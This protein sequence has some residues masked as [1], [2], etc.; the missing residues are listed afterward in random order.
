VKFAKWLVRAA[1]PVLFAVSVAGCASSSTSTLE[2]ALGNSEAS[3]AAPLAGAPGVGADPRLMQAS[4]AG[5]P[6]V[7]S[8]AAALVASATPG[9]EGYKIGPQDVLEVSVFKVAELSKAVQ[10]SDGGTINMPLIGDVPAAG[11]TSRDIE[12]DVA[13]RLGEK[14]LQNPQVS[15]FVKEF[16]SQ[17]I[18]VEGAVKKP[19]VFPYRGQ[20]T[21]LQAIAMAEGLDTMSDSEVVVFRMM[22]GKR[23]AARFDLSKVRDGGLQDPVI[24]SGDVV[25]VPTS[26]VKET[27]GAI[28]KALPLAGVFALL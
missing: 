19:G 3:S 12:R 1:L 8:S 5:S 26:T 6:L 16:N 9:S 14:Y 25:V 28:V 13:F 4:A 11:R 22:N 17:R 7:T 27:F 2:G 21:L 18:T 20:V 15:V 24:A 10:V 23:A